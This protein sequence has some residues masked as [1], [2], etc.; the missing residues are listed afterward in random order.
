LFGQFLV[1]QKIYKEVVVAD[2]MVEVRFGLAKKDFV[3]VGL[4]VVLLGVGFG[5]AY[6]GNDPAVMGHSSGELEGIPSGGV[7]AFNLEFCPTGW[8]PADGTGETPDLRGVFIR[9][10]NSFDNG[11]TTR[12]DGNEDPAIFGVRTLGS[13][14]QDGFERHTHRYNYGSMFWLGG[15]SYYIRTDYSGGSANGATTATGGDETR[16]RNIALIYCQKN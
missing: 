13:L 8:S 7:V 10:L 6:G 12:S 16:P 4:I 15:G 2:V 3:Y 11:T 9:G 14:Q 1:F 5:Y